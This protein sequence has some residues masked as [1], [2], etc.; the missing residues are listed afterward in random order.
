MLEKELNG[1]INVISLN[2][3]ATGVHIIELQSNGFYIP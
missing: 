3:L 1:N 2:E